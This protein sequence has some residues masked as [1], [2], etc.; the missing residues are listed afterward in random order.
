MP[1]IELP[2]GTIN[3][4]V[5]GPGDAKRPVVFVHGFLVNGELWHGVQDALARHGVRSYTPDWPLGSHTIPM[6]ADADQTPRGVARTIIA[7]LEAL[8]LDDVTIVGNDTGGAITQFVLDTDHTRIGRV[9]LTNCDAFENFPPA[10][11]DKLMAAGRSPARLKALLAPTRATAVRHSPL[12]F[13]LL[14]NEPLDAEMTK[15]WVT[16]CLENAGVRRDTA[17]LLKGIDP[18]ELL[19]V[20]TRLAAFDKPVLLVWGAADRFFK[21][22]FAQRLADLFPQGR[23]VA[24]DGG[25]TFIPLDDPERVADEIVAAYYSDSAP[26]GIDPAMAK[27]SSA[28]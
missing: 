16:P 20:D 4:R 6:N 27:S 12:G 24:V 22:D 14:V 11:F 13:G 19:D 10:P 28:S 5:T 1:Q 18:Q 25:R 2:Q 8:G 21:L 26:A 15:R 23:L 7:F 9:V 3:Y 17:N